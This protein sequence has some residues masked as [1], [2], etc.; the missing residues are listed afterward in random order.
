MSTNGNIMNNTNKVLTASAPSTTPKDEPAV[1][2]KVTLHLFNKTHLIRSVP[3]GTEQY[4]VASDLQ[5][6]LGWTV[7]N[8]HYHLK[9]HIPDSEKQVVK[10]HGY[11]GMAHTIITRAAV[12]E[13]ISR[14]GAFTVQ[15]FKAWLGS[16]V[17][18][19]KGHSKTTKAFPA[20]QPVTVVPTSLGGVLRLAAAQ[21][22]EID[23][24]NAELSRLTQ[25]VLSN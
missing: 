16:D 8:L 12:N 17:F 20:V 24:L 10:L 5:G 14:S 22:D 15:E 7:V 25:S 4:I 21:A 6:P 3:I 13:L 11:S 1:R 19:S 23:R 9:A 18:D 2:L